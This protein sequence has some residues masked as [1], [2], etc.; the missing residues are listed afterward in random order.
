MTTYNN[1]PVFAQL[2]ALVSIGQLCAIENQNKID[3]V[4]LDFPKLVNEIKIRKERRKTCKLLENF[5]NKHVIINAQRFKLCKTLVF[6][7]SKK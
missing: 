2:H 6:N 5:T 3:M 7:G 4:L 1:S